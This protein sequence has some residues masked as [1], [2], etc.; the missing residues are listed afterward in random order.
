V[1][2]LCRH[3]AFRLSNPAKKRPSFGTVNSRGDSDQKRKNSRGDDGGG[4]TWARDAIVGL[5]HWR[6]ERMKGPIGVGKD[7]RMDSSYVCPMA[8][9]ERME[10][11]TLAMANGPVKEQ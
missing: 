1:R 5:V 2:K 7:E 10:T 9:E 4:E 6:W 3:P 8:V 11:W